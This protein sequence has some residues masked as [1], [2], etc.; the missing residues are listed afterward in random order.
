MSRPVP[1]RATLTP[2]RPGDRRSAGTPPAVPGVS[3][4]ACVCVCVP[5]TPPAGSLPPL[6]Q[7]G[8]GGFG[9]KRC[10]PRGLRAELSN[11]PPAAWQPARPPPPVPRAPRY[12]P[13]A[14]LAP[15]PLPEPGT[16]TDRVPGPAV[17][18]PPGMCLAQHGRASHL[19]C[20]HRLQTPVSRL[21][22][23]PA[24]PPRDPQHPDRP[25]TSPSPCLTPPCSPWC[26]PEGPHVLPGPCL[27]PIPGPG[28]LEKPQA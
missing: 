12:L 19:P 7:A 13:G 4:R 28:L 26:P 11:P 20:G 15:R 9:T 27:C 23:T 1:P 14:H 6:R 25:S 21:P 22:A 24:G 18:S 10:S 3:C 5:P 17:P 16:G 2:G 8:D